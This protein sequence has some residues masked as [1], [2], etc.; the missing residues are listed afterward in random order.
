ML[1]CMDTRHELQQVMWEVIG[2]MERALLRG[3][4]DQELR[5]IVEP[6][7]W[8]YSTKDGGVILQVE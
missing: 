8:S 6:L 1:S 2:E 5:T 3:E 4:D 7:A